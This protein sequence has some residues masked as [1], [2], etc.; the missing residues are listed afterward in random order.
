MDYWGGSRTK[1]EGLL[2]DDGEMADCPAAPNG[3]K[4]CRTAIESLKAALSGDQ[5]TVKRLAGDLALLGSV[6]C[7][8]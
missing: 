3:C 1:L 8:H 2:H 7:P 4:F 6:K 5:E